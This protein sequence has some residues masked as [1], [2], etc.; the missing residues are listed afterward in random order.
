MNES[1]LQQL[2]QIKA[3]EYDC[4]LMRNNSGA[5]KDSKGRLVRFGLGNVSEKFNSISK[6][7]DLIGITSIPILPHHVGQRLGVFT[8]F[9]IKAPG[10]KYTGTPREKAQLNFINLVIAQGGIASFI[11]SESDLIQCLK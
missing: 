5:L 6:S 1:E 2:I 8:A 3:K 4:H 10:W 11:S 9:E 7:S